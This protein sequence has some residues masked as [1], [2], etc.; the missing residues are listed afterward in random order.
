M[1]YTTDSGALSCKTTKA[2]YAAWLALFK[3]HGLPKKDLLS[4]FVT[5]PISLIKK[6]SMA[7]M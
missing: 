5:R 3:E 4:G 6:G 7:R 2:M 1:L